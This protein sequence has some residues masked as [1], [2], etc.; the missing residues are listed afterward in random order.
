MLEIAT[1]KV[2]HIILKARAFDAKEGVVIPDEGSDMFDED[3]RQVLEDFADDATYDEL[4]AFIQGL[5]EDE[6]INLVALTW[7]GRETYSVEEWADAVREARDA[8]NDHTAEYLVG[9]PLLGD[10]LENG[11]AAL[12]ESCADFDAK[13]F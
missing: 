3:A 5:D 13:V 9:I 12:N 2:C 7:L 6:Q 1:D 4:V 11:L 10:Y 8:H